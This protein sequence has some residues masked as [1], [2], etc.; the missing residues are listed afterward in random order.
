MNVIATHDR[1]GEVLHPDSS[2][3][4]TTD[5]IVLVLALTTPQPIIMPSSRNH[6]RILFVILKLDNYLRMVSDIESNV[7]T[8]AY[9]TVSNQGICVLPSNTHGSTD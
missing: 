6:S 1:V 5:L 8:V 7:F 3:S 4:V 9:V 2:E